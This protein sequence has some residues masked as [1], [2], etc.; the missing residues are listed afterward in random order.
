MKSEDD[1]R[2][3]RKKAQKSQRP[4]PLFCGFLRLFA[5]N[6]NKSYRGRWPQPK[7]N[8]GGFFNTEIAE[9]TEGTEKLR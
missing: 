9:D 4:I 2:N 5:A 7:E 6:P 3:G 1:R 8:S